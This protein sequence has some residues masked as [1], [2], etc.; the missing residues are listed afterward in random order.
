M[1]LSSK[2]DNQPKVTAAIGSLIVRIGKI[3][4]FLTILY[5]I[6]GDFDEYKRLCQID[7]AC[8][9]NQ[10]KNMFADFLKQNAQ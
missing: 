4:G 7:D 9:C 10:T 5:F 8:Q 6:S 1:H 3:D 2:I